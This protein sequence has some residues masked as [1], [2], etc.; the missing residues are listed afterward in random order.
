MLI[1]YLKS[2]QGIRISS[3]ETTLDL[4]WIQFE[5]H[6]YLCLFESNSPIYSN[7]QDGDIWRAF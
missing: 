4:G 7:F 3:R 2:A 5:I 1:V 6:I